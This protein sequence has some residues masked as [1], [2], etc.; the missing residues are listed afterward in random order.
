MHAIDTD[1]TL[2]LSFGMEK[3]GSFWRGW[4]HGRR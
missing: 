1:R 4:S 2:L 3:F